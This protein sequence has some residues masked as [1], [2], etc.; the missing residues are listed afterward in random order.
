MKKIALVIAV[1]SLIGCGQMNDYM[2]LEGH[3]NDM[4]KGDT[5]LLVTVSLPDWTDEAVDTFYAHSPGKF[6]FEKEL[7]HTT[8]FLL[9][10]LP[11]DAPPIESCTRGA[12]ILAKP[13]DKI[14][15]DGSIY[16]FGAL[17]KTGG[18]YNDSLIARLDCMENTYTREIIDIFRKGM[19]AY[20]A[21]QTD[22]FLKYQMAYNTSVEPGELTELKKY[23]SDEINDSEYAAYLRLMRLSEITGTQLEE[24]YNKFTLE[25]R[26]SY[27]GKRL[28]AMIN[29]FKNI[30]QG[31]TPSAFTVKDING[32]EVDLSDYR[33]KYLLIYHWGLCPGTTW[34]HP[35]ILK[36]YDQYHERGFEVLGFTD[37][38][39]FTDHAEL[40]T[41][42][43][44]E[45]LFNHPWTTIR[46][47]VPG[48]EYIKDDYY[49]VGVPILML[50]SPDGT[51]IARGFT[52]A[53][54]QVKKA[55]EENL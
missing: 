32:N 9:S 13:G 26:Q 49:F 40:K 20:R 29:P 53:Y 3:I 28:H 5:L 42:P 30:E 36:L 21:E 46:T 54:D 35:R 55:L 7:D 6:S 8:F 23:I 45:P 50:I 19:D 33:G 25:V 38:D 43:D 14:K 39:F 24:R 44:V 52:D 18:F 27:M 22:T 47:D 48:N 1:C 16:T 31:R 37:S 10:H 11:K 4:Q 51:T 34:V 12:L 15:L 41:N 17:A 2:V